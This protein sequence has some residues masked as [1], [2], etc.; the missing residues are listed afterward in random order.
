MSQTLQTLTWVELRGGCPLR[1]NA[2]VRGSNWGVLG[3][4][5]DAESRRRGPRETDDVHVPA[6]R[7]N[8]A[9]VGSRGG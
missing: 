4:P 1:V 9:R 8:D 6:E 7:L 5:H 3:D 2:L